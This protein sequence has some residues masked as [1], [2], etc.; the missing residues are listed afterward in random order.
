MLHGAS[1]YAADV[2]FDVHLRVSGLRP[3]LTR[4]DFSQLQ[5]SD[6]ALQRAV[7]LT[8]EGWVALRCVT[9]LV[10]GQVD[11]VAVLRHRDA[12]RVTEILYT[13]QERQVQ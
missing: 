8:P 6:L 2:P 10:A 1:R 11:V 13:R 3:S 9:I 5:C 7:I 12:Q 4:W